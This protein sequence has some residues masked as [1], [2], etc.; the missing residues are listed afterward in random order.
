[1]YAYEVSCVNAEK[2]VCVYET[3]HRLP[4]NVWKNFVS[5]QSYFLINQDP[6]LYGASFLKI[7]LE[8]PNTQ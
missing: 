2:I 1:M 8:S 4:E 6:S 3:M 5:C 7:K